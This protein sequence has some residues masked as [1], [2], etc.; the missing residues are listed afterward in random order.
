MHLRSPNYTHF[1]YGNGFAFISIYINLSLVNVYSNTNKYTDSHLWNLWNRG[2][3]V[4]EYTFYFRNKS[5]NLLVTVGA[6]LQAQLHIIQDEKLDV[7]WLYNPNWLHGAQFSASQT[8]SYSMPVEH[9]FSTLLA[10]IIP[11]FLCGKLR[12]C[13]KKEDSLWSIGPLCYCIQVT[14]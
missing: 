5:V 13:K 2:L 4:W 12:G 7:G 11:P 3:I 14:N 10:H 9:W 6:N 1:S 8:P